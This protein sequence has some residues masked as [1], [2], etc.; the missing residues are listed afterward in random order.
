ME[1][2]ESENVRLQKSG[3]VLFVTYLGNYLMDLDTAKKDVE[4]RLNFQEGDSHFVLTD[5]ANLKN[6][7]K[8]AREFLSDPNGGLKGIKAGAFVSGSVFSYAILNLFL[9]INKPLVPA[10]FFSNNQQALAWFDELR[11]KAT[12]L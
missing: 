4:M 8:E 9:R 3:D 12:E 6:A 11:K 5:I 10:R 2:L 1:T 7:T